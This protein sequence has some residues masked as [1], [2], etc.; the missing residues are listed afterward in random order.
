[1]DCTLA[2]VTDNLK[3]LSTKLENRVQSNIN[4][5]SMISVM[6]KNQYADKLVDDVPISNISKFYFFK[7]KEQSLNSFKSEQLFSKVDRLEREVDE[8][9]S[10]NQGISHSLELL[11]SKLD[12]QS[13]TT[14]NILLVQQ[15]MMTT[16]MKSLNLPIPGESQD[17]LSDPKPKGKKEKESISLEKRGGALAK[18]KLKGKIIEQD[19]RPLTLPTVSVT[20]KAGQK[21]TVTTTFYPDTMLMD[22]SAPQVTSSAQPVKVNIVT[23]A[24]LQEVANSNLYHDK[25]FLEFLK[26]INIS[27]Q[28]KTLDYRNKLKEDIKYF[29]VAVRKIKGAHLR[30]II[31]VSKDNCLWHLS[32]E[33][34]E[35]LKYTELD[36]LLELIEKNGEN[37]KRLYDELKSHQFLRLPDLNS[38]P[39]TIIFQ[40]LTKTNSIDQLMIPAQL[41]MKNKDKINQVV[42]MLRAKRGFMTAEE[43]EIIQVLQSFLIHGRIP[44]SVKERNEKKDDKD[45]EDKS[46]RRRSQQRSDKDDKSE[47]SRSKSS[48]RSKDADKDKKDTQS[49]KETKKKA[50]ETNLPQKKSEAK[51]AKPKRHFHKVTASGVLK[52]IKGKGSK[53]LPNDVALKT[54]SPCSR[55]LS[56]VKHWKIKSVA[57]RT[58][59]TKRNGVI[60]NVVGLNVPPLDEDYDEDALTF[61]RAQRIFEVKVKQD[62]LEIKYTDGR[63]KEM[64]IGELAILS[65]L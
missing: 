50:S 61:L 49:K 11:N 12:D 34:L 48:K 33:T 16:M 28:G 35:K 52:W 32:F 4:S 27:V 5:N 65:N 20:S 53:I 56:Q 26:A 23:E 63:E 54:K 1:M 36:T 57:K 44:E 51:T 10:E 43:L 9:K 19:L 38:S 18:Q 46:S 47:S 21:S 39:R 40:S 59:I 6:W 58:R 15:Q 24:K 64:K 62:H 3:K 13:N 2:L 22:V 37:N 42:E 45:D 8:L 25:A 60:I 30:E 29:T 31:M 17:I 7:I 14:S 55:K 41:E